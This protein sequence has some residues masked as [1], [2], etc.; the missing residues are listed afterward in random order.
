MTKPDV[1]LPGTFTADDL[2]EFQGSKKLWEMRDI[3]ER[4]LKELFVIAYPDG[5]GDFN[6]FA[7]EKGVGDQAGAWVYFPWSGLMLHCVGPEDLFHLRTNRNQNLINAEE[8]R[9]L[10]AASVAVAGMSVGAGIAVGCVYAG[11]ADMVKLADFD[12]L[13]TANLNRLRAA[14]SDVGRPKLEL[15]A[16]EIYELNPF[17]DVRPFNGVTNENISDFL[18]GSA[19][20]V[21][22]IDDFKM[23]VQ[24]RLHAK[25]SRMPLLMFT[26]LGDNIL[27]DVER[28][29]E[30][31]DLAIFNGSISDVPEEILA[32][33]DITP[34]DARRYAVQI[35]G[36][37]YIP[38]RALGSLLEMGK[39]LV[40]RPQLYSTVA[41]DGGLA[42]YVIKSI[43]LGAPLKSGRYTIKFAELLD[44]PTSD[45]AD[46][47]E[48]QDILAKLVPR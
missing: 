21:D 29:D 16:Q 46:T 31:P 17:A 30:N 23:K 22:E 28:Y 1:L 20:V 45:L 39:T 33:E 8:Q 5:S 9:K 2:S 26:S 12:D 15:A 40:G 25:E 27:I 44:M 48:R 32:K 18:Q 34:A 41:V 37:Q 13:E 19:V 7:S 42:A 43:I 38:T 24:L 36:Q 35:V 11:I 47:G 6:A 4:Q 3:Y 14:L 10:A